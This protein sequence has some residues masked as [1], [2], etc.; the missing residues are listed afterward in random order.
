MCSSPHKPQVDIARLR[1]TDV[2]TV[3]HELVPPDGHSSRLDPA[4]MFE[5]G[6][7]ARSMTVSTLATESESD[8]PILRR[9]RVRA[10]KELKTVL[11]SNPETGELTLKIEGR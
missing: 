6:R 1:F 11:V 10:E 5:E 3:L 7:P 8:S 9:R 2:S 4:E